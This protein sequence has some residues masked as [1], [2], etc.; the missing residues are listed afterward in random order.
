MKY[1]KYK[2]KNVTPI[3]EMGLCTHRL[4]RF[5]TPI[6]GHF[7]MLWTQICY[8]YHQSWI[9]PLEWYFCWH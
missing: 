1:N 9:C 8:H 4:W 2:R 5:K 6:S 7:W 3:K